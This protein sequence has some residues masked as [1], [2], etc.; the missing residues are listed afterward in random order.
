MTQRMRHVSVVDYINMDHMNQS[1]NRSP[2]NS[3]TIHMPDI[4][5]LSPIKTQRYPELSHGHSILN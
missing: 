1:I 3:S 4:P 2:E 5:S